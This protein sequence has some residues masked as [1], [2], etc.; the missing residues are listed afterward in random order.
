MALKIPDAPNIVGGQPVLRQ[1]QQLQP[2]K[3]RFNVKLDFSGMNAAIKDTASVLAEYEQR[4][5][6]IYLGECKR[7]FTENMNDKQAQ[8]K[9]KYKGLDANNDLYGNYLA[10]YADDLIED[11]TGAPKDDGKL[12][13]ANPVLQQKFRDW[14]NMQMPSYQSN[15]LAYAAR[16]LEEGNKSIIEARLN[17][18]NQIVAGAERATSAQELG[19]AYE[20]YKDIASSANPGMDPMYI[21]QQAARYADAAVTAKINALA[22]TKPLDALDWLVN[23]ESAQSALSSGSKASIRSN[24]IEGWKDVGSAERANSSFAGDDRYGKDYVDRDSIAVLLQTEDHYKIQEF[25]DQI[26]GDAEKK[27]NAREEAVKGIRAKRQGQQAA[28]VVANYQNPIEMMSTIQNIA[29]DDE[30]HAVLLT[31]EETQYLDDINTMREFETSPI[32]WDIYEDEG[33]IE[34]RADEIIQERRSGIEAQLRKEY[35]P[36]IGQI[37][38]RTFQ[39]IV[40]EQVKQRV[41]K[42]AAKRM[43]KAGIEQTL[44]PQQAETLRKYDAMKERTAAALNSGAYMRLY[45]GA[46]NGTYTGGMNEDLK[47]MPMPLQANIYQMVTANAKI[48]EVY[49]QLPNLKGMIEKSEVSMKTVDPAFAGRLRTQVA[50]D[51]NQYRQAKGS[52][53]SDAE[54]ERIVTQASS[55]VNNPQISNMINKISEKGVQLLAA[56]NI[57]PVLQPTAAAKALESFGVTPDSFK[58]AQ[59]I[60]KNKNVF[61]G[62]LADYSYKKV[63]EQ[64]EAQYDGIWEALDRK[65]RRVLDDNKEAFIQHFIEG[66][67]ISFV[68]SYLEGMGL[69]K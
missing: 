40:D 63:Q 57:D 50:D 43:A 52:Y 56:K 69:L 29:V 31:E 59:S 7:R 48:N 42:E 60:A 8:L 49:N 6:D 5:E 28:D 62:K 37:G 17:Q 47:G 65:Q 10:P 33:W 30:E 36:V 3:E 21:N 4:K 39:R 9:G 55:K 15:M 53:P 11:I 24:I 23:D 66:G 2:G 44:T 58:L 35:E 13:I 26:E 20:A 45:N 22:K 27:R 46:M 67:D 19:V 68:V 14:A 64:A 16:E 32:F 38:E 51:I 1:P 12:R 61:K 34:T 54:L 18:A 41:P 25:I